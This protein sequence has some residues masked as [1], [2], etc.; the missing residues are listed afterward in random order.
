MNYAGKKGFTLIELLVVIA[1]IGVLAS[2]VLA[3]LNTARGKSRDAARLAQLDEVRKALHVYWLDNGTYPSES[4]ANNGST[5][6]ICKTCT[7]GINAILDQYMGSVPQDPSYNGS[8]TNSSY[9]Y[10]YDGYHLCGG[11]TPKAVVAA[12]TMENSTNSNVSDAGCASWGG[13]GSIGSTDSYMVVLGE[14]TN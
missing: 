5:G 8:H 12:I 9:Y 7:G 10:Y 1:I 13:E 14:G 6:Y 11:T 4:V 3:S 2:V